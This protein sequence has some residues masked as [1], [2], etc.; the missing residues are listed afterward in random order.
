MKLDIC[1]LGNA[2]VDV[3]FSIE[4]DFVTKLKKMSIPK[5]SMTLI[6]AEEQCN[7]I[8]LLKEEYG[9]PKLSCGGAGTNSTVA[10][11]NFGSSCHFSCK[12]R[13]DD[14][15]IFYLDNLSKN[16]VLHSKQT[17]ES[18]LSTGQS[19]IMVTPDA[20]RTMCT[21]LGISNLFSKNDLDKLAIRNSKYLFIEGYLVASE[22]SLKACFEAIEIAKEAN[23]QIAF[24][25]SAAAIVNNFRDQINS[26]IE[27]GCEIL[28]CNESEACAFSQ[29]NDVLKAEKLLR[30]ISS[31][32]LI[33]LGKN[34]SMIWD[35]SKLETIKG[36]KT[37]A[38]DTNGAGDIF[39]GSVLHKICEGYGLKAS[40]EF[41]CFAASK[42]VEKFGPRL[43]K[44][45]Y[46]NIKL[47]FSEFTRN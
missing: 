43:S 34:G 44:S 41:G 4:E 27:L 22:S 16:D 45:E 46:K 13:N 8:S 6:E 11:S 19:V 40:A 30:D 1:A 5:G 31:Q 2:I 15:G 38:I 21:Y 29:Q 33:T 14:L 36:F 47:K 37:K 12:V 28:F 18:E 17:S 32:N 26:L 20:E 35:G 3:Q 25:L 10:A 7:L 9:E 24:S 39:A 42:K 23:T